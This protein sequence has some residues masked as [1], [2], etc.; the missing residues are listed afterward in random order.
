[1]ALWWALWLALAVSSLNVFMPPS[2][3]V[4]AQFAAFIGCFCL[5]HW[6]ARLMAGRHG[7][8]G[9]A[10][11]VAVDLRLHRSLLVV[12]LACLA[13]LLLSMQMSGA[14]S[15]SFLDYFFKL[16]REENTGESLTGS[17]I[18][19]VTTKALVWPT[20]Y[21]FTIVVL[22]VRVAGRKIALGLSV[23][24]ILLFAYLWQVNY[25][26]IYLFW[27]F[28]FYALVGV[29]RGL[30]VDRMVLAFIV[31]LLA[32]LVAVA[33]NR[34][35]GDVL[36]GLQRY[37]FGY[38][39]AGFSFYDHHYRDPNSLLHQH[40]LGRSSLGFIEQFAEIFTRR[41]DLGF[42][43]ASSENSTFN[44]EEVDIGAEEVIP[45]NAFGTFLYGFYR[46][47]HIVG[48]AAGGLVY[49]AMATHLLATGRRA[50]AATAAFY[51]LGTSWMVGMMV[52][53]I[54]QTHFWFSLILLG[55]L[56][57]LNRGIRW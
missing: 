2:A 1:M 38:H 33:A 20:A 57:V 44:N 39:T 29:S 22:A 5:G 9:A 48:I 56:A 27:F 18:L 50:W 52:N 54:E 16:R 14:L 8:A 35:G 15:E 10:A 11:A 31:T 3:A 53:P 26:L 17:R 13:V 42:V 55:M 28:V 12:N 19:D 21:T 51:V 36:G 7:R 24:N 43:A 23:L 37:V 45:G 41:L 25:P 30:P 34:F 47:F 32:L 40:S 4:A 49:G 46:D 6:L